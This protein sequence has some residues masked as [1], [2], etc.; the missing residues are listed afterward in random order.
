MPREI[1]ATFFVLGWI[2]ERLPNYGKEVRH[3]GHEIASHGYNHDLCGTINHNDLKQ[4][5]IKSKKLLEDITGTEIYGYRAPSFS[6]DNDIL[7]VIQDCGYLYDSSY[8]SFGLHGRYGKV[9]LNGQPKNGI[10]IK[11]SDT[12]YELPISNLKLKIL[13]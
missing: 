3:R 10:A 12:F 5:L 9:N 13:S 1:K 2:A 7:N 11:L 8:N 4:D 6:I